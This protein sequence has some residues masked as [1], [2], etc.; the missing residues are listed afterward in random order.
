MNLAIPVVAIAGSC[1]VLLGIALEWWAVRNG[2]T[3]GR[4]DTSDAWTSMIMGAGSLVMNAVLAFISTAVLALAASL[5]PWDIGV[6][7]LSIAGAILVHDFLYY[8]K[9]R[10]GHRSRLFWAE[11][12]THHSS[13]Y[14]NLTTAVRQPWTGPLSNVLIIGGPMV[15][16]G[17][18]VSLVLTATITHLIYQ[19][20]IHTEA[21]DRLP[22]P[23]EAI[24]VTP[25]HH[26]V[27]HATNPQYLDSN[28][29]GILI[30]WDRLFG[31]FVRE[32]ESEETHY[33][34][35]KQLRSYNPLVVAY[36]G[37]GALLADMRRDGL[38]PVRWG[39]RAFNP[40]GW[41]PDGRHERSEEI[42]AAWRDRQHE[43]A[44]RMPDHT[45]GAETETFRVAAE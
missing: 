7:A 2:H 28:Y 31:T 13:R 39:R 8:W 21:I 33:G 1:V 32:S 6:S 44:E 20:W 30:V 17:F 25:S 40:P 23:I 15:A 11:H 45:E 12:V 27:H 10:I 3:K 5:T 24:L 18:P 35:V 42:K 9:H 29:G 34:L 37:F 16:L 38:L 36:H 43:A 14:F 4:Y 19:I 41:S 26:R 22:A